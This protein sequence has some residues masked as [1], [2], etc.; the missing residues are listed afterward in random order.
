MRFWVDH[1]PG[2]DREEML[3][4]FEAH[5]NATAARHPFLRDHPPTLERALMR[6]FT[7][8]SVSPDAPIVRAVA[9]AASAIVGREVPTVGLEAATDAMIFNLYSDVP[10]V[11][12]C[13]GALD[14]AHAPNEYAEV[15][16]VWRSTSAL[17]LAILEFC[18]VER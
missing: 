12:F 10:A 1:L 3:A 18:G 16:D 14:A 11:I 9:A 17:A 8:V 6:P 4:R 7:G 15:D 2:E 13:G 5:I